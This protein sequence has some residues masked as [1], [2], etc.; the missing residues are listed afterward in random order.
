MKAQFATVEAA[1]SLALVIPAIISVSN[2]INLQ[3]ANLQAQRNSAIRNAALYD[4]FA[5]FAYNSAAN[6]CLS[7]V[8]SINSSCS[9]GLLQN[10]TSLLGVGSIT[11]ETGQFQQAGAANMTAA[12]VPIPLRQA[13]KTEN[14]CISVSSR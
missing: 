13:N 14:V 11:V 12:C 4:V 9:S 6:G 1:I 2:Q 8:Y 7:L 5:V 3:N 10:Y